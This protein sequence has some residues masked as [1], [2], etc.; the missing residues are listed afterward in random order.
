M[1]VRYQGGKAVPATPARIASRSEWEHAAR[2]LRD[3]WPDVE[4]ALAVFQKD[5]TTQAMASD[6][7]FIVQKLENYT[8]IAF[9]NAETRNRPPF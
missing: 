5:Q 1:A 3:S 2:L 4:K 6:L 8:R 7:R 9:Q